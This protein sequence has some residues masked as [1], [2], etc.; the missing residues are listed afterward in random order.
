MIVV[1]KYK[2]KE[3]GKVDVISDGAEKITKLDLS[4]CRKEDLLK[5]KLSR[6]SIGERQGKEKSK[7][8]EKQTYFKAQ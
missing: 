8:A 3:K 5:I 6:L 2:E 1:L 4:I 7:V